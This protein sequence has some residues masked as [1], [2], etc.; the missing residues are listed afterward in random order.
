MIVK[1][2]WGNGALAVAL[3]TAVGCLS[4]AFALTDSWL[5]LRNNRVAAQGC[6]QPCTVGDCTD[7]NC[8]TCSNGTCQSIIGAGPNR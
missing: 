6:N 5:E 7:S 3:L 1:L 8:P 4:A 2:H